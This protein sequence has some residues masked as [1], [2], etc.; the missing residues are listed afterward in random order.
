LNSTGLLRFSVLSAI[1][2]S[3]CACGGS[4]GSSSGGGTPPPPAT[5]IL[6][7]SNTGNSIFAFQIDQTSGVLTETAAV[8][9]GEQT[10]DNTAIALTPKGTFLYAVNDTTAAIN[11][12]SAGGSGALSLMAGS[13]FPI[14]PAVQPSW[15]DVPALVVDPL[16]RFL[17]AG[18][19]AG[20]GGI[21]SFSI[22]SST[23][24][25]TPT[26]GPFA[27]GN[28]LPVG[29]AINPAGSFLYATD[30][31]QSVWA[32]S[33]NPQTGTLTVVAGSPFSAG[34]QPFGLQVDPSGQFLYVALANYNGIAAFSINNASGALATVPGSPFPT[35][36]QYPAYRLTIH[37]S[38]KF[39]Y[40]VNQGVDNTVG[41][42]TIDSGT[43]ALSPILGS[44]FALN[45]NAEGDLLVDPSGKLLYLTNGQAPPSAFVV[46][47]IDMSTGALT[48]NPN[49]PL[50]GTEQP[51]GLA[52]AQF[53]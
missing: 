34:S 33:I 53:Q 49:S 19:G 5:E 38:G 45:P 46:F 26:G 21:A 35:S 8:A 39:L 18:T 51:W 14:L 47:D 31:F 22:D 17:Y 3:F 50:A 23:G 32:F 25:L 30:Q 29:I 28:A 27:M 36:M 1:A 41:G 4:G 52:A 40:A 2:F 42:F 48:P 6:Y 9:P 44:P 43:G 20:F 15:P 10:V 13:P 11:C 16:G 12:Y 24:T 7:A 37:P